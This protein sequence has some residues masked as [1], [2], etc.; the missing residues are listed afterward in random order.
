MTE[1]TAEENASAHFHYLNQNKFWIDE[2]TNK[3][4]IVD[5]TDSHRRNAAKWLVNRARQFEFYYSMGEM[6]WMNAP[7]YHGFG[8]D[9]R[10]RGYMSEFDLMSDSVSDEFNQWIED[11]VANPT[12]WIVETPLY[13]ALLDG[14][15]EAQVVRFRGEVY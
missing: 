14:V 3:Y 6:L 13:K 12:A 5:M 1:P 11:R 9:G 4:M 10:D 8:I 7:R 2:Q 15:P